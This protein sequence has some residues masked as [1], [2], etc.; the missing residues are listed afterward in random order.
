MRK[1]ER[2][3]AEKFVGK[4]IGVSRRDSGRNFFSR[5][6]LRSVS[7][8]CLIMERDGRTEVIALAAVENLREVG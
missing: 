8:S 1:M 6:L 2:E 5:G 3:I 7:E 4:M